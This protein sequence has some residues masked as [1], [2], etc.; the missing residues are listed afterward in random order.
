[1]AEMTRYEHGV[2]SWVDMGAPDPQAALIF[3]SELLGWEGQDM[4]E[5]AGHYTIVSKNGKMVAAISPAQQQPGPPWWSTYI[6][7]DDVDQV[8][9][10]AEAAG[11]EVVVAPMDV[12]TAGR[13]AVY[14]D[15]TG[16]FISAWQPQDHPGAQL[17]NQPGAFCWCELGSSDLEKSKRF[18][19]DV[20]GWGWGGAPEYAEAQVA[21]RS[22]AGVMPRPEAI[23]AEVPDHWLVYFGA[24]DVDGDAHKAQSLGAT[25]VVEPT[26]IPNMGRFAVFLDPQGAVFALYK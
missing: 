13:M 16:A 14:R 22:I 8:T 11:G 4:G 5:E 15:T 24:S 19:A 1:M 26:D 12:M 2:P 6:N 25:Q 7:V 3:Y 18:Y 23:P 10:K 21:G 20:F 17:V 9:K